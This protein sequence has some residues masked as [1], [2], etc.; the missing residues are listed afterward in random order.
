MPTLAVQLHNSHP[1]AN[2]FPLMRPEA[3]QELT[4]D[5]REHGLHE[6]I[7]L[8]DDKVLDG[9]NRERACGWAEV[10]PRY[11]QFD[12]NEAQALD[13]VVSLNLRRRHLSTSQRGMVAAKIATMRQGQR[14]DLSPIG[15][16]SQAAAAKALNV[17]KRS[18]E[19]AA[20][21]HHHGSPELV[22]AVEAGIVPVSTA[23]ELAR[24]PV[25]RQREI[26]VSM[27]RG[28]PKRVARETT[29]QSAAVTDAELEWQ[30]G[31]LDVCRDIIALKDLWDRN[32]TNWQTRDCPPDIKAL[33]KQA[34]TAFASIAETVIR[35]DE[36]LE[37]A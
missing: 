18:V 30:H 2:L 28:A 3:L 25:E 7:I 23:A 20:I 36:N 4:D 31:L 22:E 16:M 10:E 14:T 37:A 9:R 26:V 13:L 17:G 19:R 12:G 11:V 27:L 34:A 8:F 15:G 32:H 1:L 33:V 21:V 6:P 29:K 24:E 5:I 35:G